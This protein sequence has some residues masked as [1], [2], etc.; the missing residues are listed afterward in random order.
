MG[1]GICQKFSPFF[2]PFYLLRC[3]TFAAQVGN[4]SHLLKNYMQKVTEVKQAGMLQMAV[5]PEAFLSKLAEGLEE[6]KSLLEEKAEAEMNSQWIESGEARKILGI[7]QKT[8]QTY[9]DK[10]LIPFSQ[11]GRKIYVK[12]ADLEAFL[13]GNKIER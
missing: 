1:G 11:F 12:R 5:I 3:N 4:Q 7:S 9:R 13:E 8:W 6:V 2:T 10:R